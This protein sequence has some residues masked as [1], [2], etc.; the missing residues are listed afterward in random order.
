MIRLEN[1]TKTTR[2][3]VCN[4]DA[5]N[6]SW[7]ENEPEVARKWHASGTQVAPNNNEKNEKNEKNEDMPRDHHAITPSESRKRFS[8][9]TVS[10]VDAYCQERRNTVDPQRF[11]D[12][13]ES[14]GWKV[15]N[16]PMKDWKA[17]VRTW[18]K[19]SSQN[20]QPTQ[21]VLLDIP[22]VPREELSRD[23]SSIPE[24]PHAPDVPPVPRDQLR[25]DWGT[26]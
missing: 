4:Y 24:R 17:A 14:K 6:T 11:H 8:K 9:P 1:V 21:P 26:L 16:A 19:S 2:L 20:S 23:W 18:E 10:E 7:N 5:Y 12:Y 13:N 3:T 25:R 22:P 15:G